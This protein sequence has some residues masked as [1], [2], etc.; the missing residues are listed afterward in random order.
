MLKKGLKF[1]VLIFVLIGVFYGIMLT[2]EKRNPEKNLKRIEEKV[3]SKLQVQMAELSS[4]YTFGKAISVEGKISNISKDNLESVKLYITDGMEFEETFML[5]YSFEENKV[6][7]FPSE[8]INTG[9]ILDNFEN[10]EYYLLLRLKLNNSYEPRYYS[11]RNT[12]KAKGFEYYTV[13]EEG[14]NKKVEVEFLDKTYKENDYKI[15]KMNVTD[16]SLP[17]E[18]YDIVIDAGH[19]G[20]DEG[21]KKDGITES[22]LTLDYAKDLKVKLEEK[23]YKVKLTRDDNN[24]DIYTYTNMYNPEGRI[25]I[26]CKSKAKLMI[27]LHVNDGAEDKTGFEI[28]A[29]TKA[30][31]SFAKSLAIKIDEKVSLTYSNN[32]TFKSQD[33]VYVRAYTKRE[34]AD[35][36]ATAKN[37]GY[38]PYPTTTTTPYHYTIREVGGIAQEA[39]V[40]GRN[41]AYAK[42]DFY[43]SNQGIECYQLELGYIDTDLEV[44][45]N[46]KANY[47]EAIAE[48]ISKNY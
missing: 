21:E 31:L 18:V 27:S 37:K 17:E 1:L 14:K 19:G 23:G 38:E 33:G 5:D 46:E 16:S 32:T 4:V 15:L 13:T 36:A 8:K 28:Y 34:I 47:I 20:K 24:T 45:K 6:L 11:F 22:D 12:E 42:N 9:L 35:Q 7:F 43:D 25:Q 3:F 44:L 40:D 2:V 41:T 10:G 39:Y 30:D 48:A 29:P 26:A